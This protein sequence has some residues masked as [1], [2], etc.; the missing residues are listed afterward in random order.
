MTY[1]KYYG[2]M[3]HFFVLPCGTCEAFSLLGIAILCS[4]SSNFCFETIFHSLIPLCGKI[5]HRSLRLGTRKMW[6]GPK[7]YN[8]EP[9]DVKIPI[10]NVWR[11]S[12]QLWHFVLPSSLRYTQVKEMV[13]KETAV[14]HRSGSETQQNWYQTIWQGSKFLAL[15]SS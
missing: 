5:K 3:M 11:N 15:I 10:L 1:Q 6:A 2:K 12:F 8:I 7:I 9:I 13:S 14:V 4:G